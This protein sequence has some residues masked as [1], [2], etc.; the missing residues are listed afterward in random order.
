[1]GKSVSEKLDINNH[2]EIEMTNNLFK[3]INVLEDD[4]NIRK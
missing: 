4:L 2:S 1:L 3:E